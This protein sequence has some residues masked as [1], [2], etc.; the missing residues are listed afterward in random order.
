MAAVAVVLLIACANVANL[1]IARAA[2]RRKE[3]AVRLALGSSRQR[4][5][6]Q[7]LTESFVL[8]LLGAAFGMALAFWTARLLPRS[9]R[10][11]P[12]R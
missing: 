12:G 8:A 1:L 2:S 6:R 11:T 5:I 4:L 3:I 9:F 10:R 7:M